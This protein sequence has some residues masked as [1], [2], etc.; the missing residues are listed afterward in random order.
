[1]ADM[2]LVDAPFGL[3]PWGPMRV[4]GCHYYAIEKTPDVALFHGDPVETEGVGIAT[5]HMGV[6]QSIEVKIGGAAAS[7]VGVIVGL[8]DEDM[9]PVKYLPIT[10]TGTLIAGYALVCD[11]PYQ[12]YIIQEDGDGSSIDL[13]N[14]GLNGD[15]VAVAGNTSTGRSKCV[16]DSSDVE[17]AGG[18]TGD[19]KVLACHP[20]DTIDVKG[21]GAA[22]GYARFIVML[23]SAYMASHDTAGI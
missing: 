20:E 23:N 18:A 21:S 19:V 7:L 2:A 5:P 10:A 3:E 15:I 8:F 4:D 14:I 22:G 9:S 11:D 17:A 13:A 12:K 1:M 6:L 16:L